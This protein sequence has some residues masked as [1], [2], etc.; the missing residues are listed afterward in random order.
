MIGQI[1]CQSNSKGIANNKKDPVL[2]FK[3]LNTGFTSEMGQIMGG[4]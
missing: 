3:L 4:N 1:A 2:H